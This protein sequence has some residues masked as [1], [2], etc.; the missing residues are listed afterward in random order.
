MANTR[1]N[2]EAVNGRLIARLRIRASLTQAQLALKIGCPQQ[3]ISRWET[4]SQVPSLKS[5][6]ALAKAL[7]C[8]LD[9][10]VVE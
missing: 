2:C 6:L 3:T 7:Q 8:S 10:L 5:L 1:I 4:G 9:Q